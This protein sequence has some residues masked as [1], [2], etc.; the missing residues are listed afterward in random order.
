M[1][2]SVGSKGSVGSE[3]TVFFELS[4]S[5]T[6]PLDDGFCETKDDELGFE[7][8]AEDEEEV[9]LDEEPPWLEYLFAYQSFFSMPFVSI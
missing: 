6:V 2:G 9:L 3:E 4:S 1:F 7:E 5:L 8:E